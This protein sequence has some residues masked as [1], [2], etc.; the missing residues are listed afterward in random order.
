MKRVVVLIRKISGSYCFN[1]CQSL[2]QI[3]AKQIEN[4]GQLASNVFSSNRKIKIVDFKNFSSNYTQLDALLTEANKLYP[5]K[6]DFSNKT[7]VTKLGMYGSSSYPM[8][9]LR[10]LKVSNEAPFSGASPQIDVSYTGLDRD[11]LVELFN[12]LPTVTGSQTL[13]CVGAT[14]TA[15][16]TQ[17][18]KDIAT[19]KGWGLQLS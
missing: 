13:K 16:L 7:N 18:D 2:E 8:R 3:S 14:G 17:A 5:T 4:T 10:G 15:D 6:I 19:A 11:A 1:N 12:S 9:G